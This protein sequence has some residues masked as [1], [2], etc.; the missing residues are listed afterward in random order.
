MDHSTGAI[1]SDM[2]VFMRYELL[3]SKKKDE[4]MVELWQ[5]YGVSWSWYL[6]VDFSKEVMWLW[7]LYLQLSLVNIWQYLMNAIGLNSKWMKI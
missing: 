3:A 2:G 1:A 6:V 4:F 7:L 5:N